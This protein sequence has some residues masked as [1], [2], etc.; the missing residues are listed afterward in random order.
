[1]LPGSL[2]DSCSQWGLKVLASFVP[3]TS[4]V[5]IFWPVKLMI[6]INKL[7][8]VWFDEGHNFST[9]KSEVKL[10]NVPQITDQG[11]QENTFLGRNSLLVFGNKLVVVCHRECSV[12]SSFWWLVKA[13]ISVLGVNTCFANYNHNYIS[14]GTYKQGL[15]VKGVLSLS[16]GFSTSMH[17]IWVELQL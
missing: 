6:N 5:R 3:G 13:E 7:L 8:K 4:H 15:H 11:S 14:I 9:Q 10:L 17:L 2:A 1:M 12:L 16:W